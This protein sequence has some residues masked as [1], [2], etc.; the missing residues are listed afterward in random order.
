MLKTIIKAAEGRIYS[1]KRKLKIYK[2]AKSILKD[3]SYEEEWPPSISQTLLGVKFS[4]E[5]AY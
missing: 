2:K 5:P 4:K 1:A 3:Y